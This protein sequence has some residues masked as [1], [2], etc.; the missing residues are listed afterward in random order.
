MAYNLYKLSSGC[1]YNI[2]YHIVWCPKYRKPILVDSVAEDIKNLLFQKA[3]EIDVV[4]EALEVMPD[5]I[6]LF[7]S[8][9]PIMLIHHIVQQFKGYT[10]H[11][12]RSKYMDIKRKLPTLWSRSYYVGTIGF[13]SET[14]VR[15]YI[16]QQKGK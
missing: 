4:I 9:K 2:A 12:I 14:T 6:H 13:V 16:A 10:S 15:N 3:K 1:V 7:V 8:C 11:E 5:H